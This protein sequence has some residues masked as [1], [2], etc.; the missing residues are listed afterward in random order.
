MFNIS[1][2]VVTDDLTILLA[3]IAATTF[4]LNNLYKPQPL[5]HPILLGRQ[6]D[7]GRARNPGES[8]VYRNYGTGLMGRFPVRPSKEIAILPHLIKPESEASRT[9][10]ATRG[11]NAGLQDRIAALGSGLIRLAGLKPGE[12]KVLLLLNDG[13]E[14]IIADFAL[15]THSVISVTLN[16]QDLLKRVLESQSFSAIIASPEIVPRVLETIYASSFN[17]RPHTIVIAGDVSQ[18][19]LASVASNIKILKFN[20]V[21]R[22]GIKVDKLVSKLPEPSDIYTMT[23]LSNE[24]GQLQVAQL[25][26]ENA[27]AGVAA[28][29]SLLPI[30]HALSPLDT[31]ISAFS[32]STAY[33]R[34]IAYTAIYEGASFA[35]LPSSKMY[36]DEQPAA[37]A[38]ASDI[39][40]A[41]RY[42]IP[43]PTIM[44]IQPGHLIAIV[45]DILKNAAGSMFLFPFARRHKLAGI[46]DGFITRESLWDRLVFDGA[47]AKVIGD[48]AATLRGVI[49]SGRSLPA[50][51]MTPARMALSVPLVNTFTHPLVAGP[52][53]ASH[54]FDLQDFTEEGV[55]SEKKGH[56]GPP[57]VNVEAK[58]T[59]VDDEKVENGG[60]P[61]GLLFV[62]GPPVGKI[63]NGDQNEDYVQVSPTEE[64]RVRD[65]N[66][67]EGWISTGVRAQVQPNG[68]FIV[69]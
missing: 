22:E 28:T 35:T 8:A 38:D 42:P 49:V 55:S 46:S 27:T 45:T 2:Y 6:S 36:H 13:I 64:R 5:V 29:R 1:D 7:V 51:L 40:A 21:E 26:H 17:S 65:E 68:S 56:V 48:G 15:A 37:P 47:R 61:A 53:L 52:V 9:L 4:L 18:Q 54:P 57:S 30:S 58:L 67:E 33:G 63:G 25:T 34:V 10:W 50:V 23:Y 62:R 3:L 41:K 20:E 60:D 31:I 43:S 16:S 12:S 59:G 24:A 14:F 66:A 11:T 19:T 69:L 39:L 44:F 32:L